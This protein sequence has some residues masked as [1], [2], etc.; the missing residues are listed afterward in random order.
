MSSLRDFGGGVD[1]NPSPEDQVKINLSQWFESHGATVYWEKRP[2]YGHSVFHTQTGERPDLLVVGNS[3]TFAVEVKIPDG[4]GDVYSGTAQTFRYWNRYCVEDNEEFYKANGTERDITAFLLATKF[5]P[6]G[7]LSQRYDTQSRIRPLPIYDDRRIEWADPPIHFLPDYE[8]GVSE[9]ITR[10]LWRFA[11]ANNDDL[12]HDAEVGIG[13]MLST[14][15]DGS[16]P[17]VPDVDAPGPFGRENMPEP[18][19]LYKTFDDDG[20]ISCQN[21]RTL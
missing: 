6:D 1:D 21:W 20:G 7:R 4:V 11:T 17:D 19:A 18:C 2:S 13:S 14:R 12:N 10:L 16:Q 9:S 8:F 5:S 15:L 3:R